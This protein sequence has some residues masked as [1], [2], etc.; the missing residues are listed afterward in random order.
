MKSRAIICLAIA[1]QLAYGTLAT[2]AVSTSDDRAIQALVQA[3]EK[4]WNAHD[5]AAMGTLITEDADFVNV[6]GLHWK[7]R[8]QIVQEHAERHRTNLKL[9]HWITHGVTIQPLSPTI[10]LVHITWG[11][12]GDT[13][14]DGTPREPRDGVFSWIVEKHDTRWLIRAVQNTN[15]SPRK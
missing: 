11:M 10:A 13:D 1:A 14:F 4:D 6:A 9:S 5:M 15:V 2:A 12:T 8:Q 3:W 7:G